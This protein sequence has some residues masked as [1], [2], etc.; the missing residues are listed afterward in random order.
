MSYKEKKKM[1]N[2]KTAP[3][4]AILVTFGILLWTVLASLPES[5]N[6]FV[7]KIYA[8]PNA[9]WMYEGTFCSECNYL[10]NYDKYPKVCDKCGSQTKDFYYLALIKE[11]K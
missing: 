9:T 8:D 1:N 10:Y 7:G 11:R 4:I 5:T 2:I 3:A 6:A